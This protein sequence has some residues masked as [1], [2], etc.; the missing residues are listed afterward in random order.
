MFD[1]FVAD[2][3]AG[4][5]D[6]DVDGQLEDAALDGGVGQGKIVAPT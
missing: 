2:A 4:C 1:L 6:L 5:K 3:V